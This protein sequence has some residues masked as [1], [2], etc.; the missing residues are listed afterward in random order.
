MQFGLVEFHF[1]YPLYYLRD[2]CRLD[3]PFI[4]KLL[5]GWDYFVHAY[6]LEVQGA[7]LNFYDYVACSCCNVNLNFFPE[8]LLQKLFK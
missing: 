8:I 2:I 3:Y 5:F 6:F 7:F 1:L 4:L